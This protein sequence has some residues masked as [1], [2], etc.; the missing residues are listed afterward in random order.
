MSGYSPSEV[1]SNRIVE[2]EDLMLQSTKKLKMDGHVGDSVDMVDSEVQGSKE[3][4]GLE[5]TEVPATNSSRICK[6][7]CKEMELS[8]SIGSYLT[9]KEIINV[10]LEDYIH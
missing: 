2:E 1:A 3:E 4:S 5:G 10:V 9:P 8:E 6:L 7:T